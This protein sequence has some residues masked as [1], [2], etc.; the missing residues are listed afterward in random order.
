METNEHKNAGD[1]IRIQTLGN[2]YLKGSKN[3]SPENTNNLRLKMM[4]EVDGIPV[5]LEMKLSAGDIV[6][7]AGDYY[8]KAG[9]WEQLQ[10]PAKTG[11]GTQ[12][13]ERLLHTPVMQAETDAFKQAF[14]DLASPAV[15]KS[16]ISRIFAIDGSRFIPSL[17]KQLIYAV[18]VKEYG[19]KLASNEDH[20][21]PW[22]LRG[23]IVGHQSALDMA[24]TAY[25]CHQIAEGKMS[26]EDKKIPQEIRDRLAK[27]LQQI[28]I[29]PAKYKL[30]PESKEGKLTEKELF[31]ELGH[32]F[33]AMAVARDLFAMHF[34]S[35]HFAGG[36]LSRMGE[37]RK[38][39]PKEFGVLGSILV[40][41]MHNE[42]NKDSVAVTNSFQ[43]LSR[44]QD[45]IKEDSQ[46]Y[47][48]GTYFNHE[49]DANANMLINGMDNSLGDIARLMKTGE[50][51]ES[52]EYGGLEFLPQINYKVSQ[53]QPLLIQDPNDKKIYF[54]SDVKHI[55]MLS[56]NEYT[57]T[58]KNPSLHGYQELTPTKAFWLVVKLWLF[59]F[60]YS[61][62]VELSKKEQAKIRDVEQENESENRQTDVQQ[63]KLSPNPIPQSESHLSMMGKWR[64]TTTSHSIAK[65]SFLAGPQKG[66]PEETISPENGAVYSQI[67]H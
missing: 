22:S 27:I 44:E 5:P 57:E 35:D 1:Q 21:A 11:D 43:P 23:Y 48:D 13:N 52:V 6:A 47:G 40:N 7:L 55:K 8:T 39:L 37:M 62:Q 58:T 34:Y 31:T 4:Q 10:I 41:T 63:S 29:D 64:K 32:R 24:E 46:A 18:T 49:N 54:R 38:L 28:A 50:K 56:P 9:W 17:L 61:P 33:H 12:E 65:Q 2:R 36:H 26:K 15:T 66:N 25:Y 20:F 14:D 59:P 42:D 3:L 67:N 19:A 16:A 30:V 45:M 53:P 51:R 60:Y